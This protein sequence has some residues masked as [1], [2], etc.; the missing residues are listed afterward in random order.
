[1]NNSNNFNQNKNSDN[2]DFEVNQT[3]KELMKD[4]LFVDMVNIVK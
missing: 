4:P 2:E 1:M 3:F